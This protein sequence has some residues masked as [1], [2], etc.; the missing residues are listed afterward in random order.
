MLP[1]LQQVKY[2]ILAKQILILNVVSLPS[3]SNSP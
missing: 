3:S 2:S 1:G